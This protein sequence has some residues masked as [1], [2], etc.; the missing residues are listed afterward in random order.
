MHNYR[1]PALGPMSH[2]YRGPAPQLLKPECPRGSKPQLL[3][4]CA[5]T[6]EAHAPRACASQREKPA[7]C[8]AH[9][10]QPESSPHSPQLEKAHANQLRPGAANT[11]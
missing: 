7:Q 11:K 10:P 3:S 2:N 6:T 1:A 8:K 9:A 4:L 5:A